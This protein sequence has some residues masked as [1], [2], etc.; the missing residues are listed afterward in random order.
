MLQSLFP[1]LHVKVESVQPMRAHFRSPWP[2]GVSMSV[3]ADPAAPCCPHLPLAYSDSAGDCDWSLD[4]RLQELQEGGKDCTAFYM[5]R[6]GGTS[7]ELNLSMQPMT[8][9]TGA[10]T[11]PQRRAWSIA[12]VQA[13]TQAGGHHT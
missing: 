3:H 8:V 7:G 11:A 1:Q 10:T 13:K 12:V 4:W 6:H 5:H 2:H 9:T